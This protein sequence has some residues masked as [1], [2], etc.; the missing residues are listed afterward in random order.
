MKKGETL[1]YGAT[2]TCPEDDWIGTLPI[3]YADGLI[4]GL[5][6]QDVLVRGERMPIVGRICMDQCLI[7]LTEKVPPG[8]RVQL[9]GSQKNTTILIEEWAEKLDT[10]PYEIPCILTKRVPRHYI[11]K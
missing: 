5:Q 4:R 3:G 1:S 11:G 6:G 9:L 2:Y 8:E 10:I 7:R